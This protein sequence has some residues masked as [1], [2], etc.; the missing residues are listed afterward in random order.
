LVHCLH[1]IGIKDSLISIIQENIIKSKTPGFRTGRLLVYYLG[2]SKIFTLSLIQWKTQQIC[3][4]YVPSVKADASGSGQSWLIA[5][6]ALC[7]NLNIGVIHQ[8]P[9]FVSRIE[10]LTLFIWVLIMNNTIGQISVY[11]FVQV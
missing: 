9:W 5:W 10:T 11:R 3:G 1:T 4:N 2:I 6:V 8:F 7:F